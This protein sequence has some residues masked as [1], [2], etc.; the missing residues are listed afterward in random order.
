MA[1]QETIWF[2]SPTVFSLFWSFTNT[3]TFYI[4]FV[5]MIYDIISCIFYLFLSTLYYYGN[6]KYRYVNTNYKILTQINLK[7]SDRFNNQYS[8]YVYCFS[9][10]QVF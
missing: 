10:S 8:Y 5:V 6:L 2:I 7:D 9:I 1:N 4:Y 3:F